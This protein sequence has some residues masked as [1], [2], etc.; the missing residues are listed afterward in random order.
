[1]LYTVSTE[2]F[3]LSTGCEFAHVEIHH[4]YCR[5]VTIQIHLFYNQFDYGNLL[6]MVNLKNECITP[7]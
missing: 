1:M 5:L 3:L 6:T 7:V 4:F 2:P